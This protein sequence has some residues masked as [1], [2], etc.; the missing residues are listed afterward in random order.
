MVTEVAQLG[1]RKAQLLAGELFSSE[2][3]SWGLLTHS[4]SWEGHCTHPRLPHVPAVLP[5]Y[6][7]QP[8]HQDNFKSFWLTVE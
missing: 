1:A 5:C 6:H 7:A 8:S 3:Q 2:M 4:L